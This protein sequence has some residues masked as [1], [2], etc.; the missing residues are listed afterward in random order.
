MRLI[1][2]IFTALLLPAVMFVS[3]AGSVQAAEYFKP[4]VLASRGPGDF[5]AKVQATRDAL[6]KAGCEKIF[7]DQ[8]NGAKP[9]SSLLICDSDSGKCI[10]KCQQLSISSTR[11]F[12]S[13]SSDIFGRSLPAREYQ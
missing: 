12:H 3:L 5:D 1:K 13:S 11:S 4:F 8:A 10:P 2:R 9:G 7:V 6:K